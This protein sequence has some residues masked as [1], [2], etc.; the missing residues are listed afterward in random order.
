MLSEAS[1][2][3]SISRFIVSKVLDKLAYITNTFCREF[4]HLGAELV[5]LSKLVAVGRCSKSKVGKLIS[6][7]FD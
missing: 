2:S 7:A 1:L 6:E 5:N 3:K 4:R